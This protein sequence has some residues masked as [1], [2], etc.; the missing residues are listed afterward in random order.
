MKKHGILIICIIAILMTSSYAF[1]IPLGKNITVYDGMKG[2]WAWYGS[3]EDDEVEPGNIYTQYWDLEGF[4]LN[5]STLTMVGG[6]DFAEGYMDQASGDIFIDIDNDS[7]FGPANTDSGRDDQI[8]ENTFGYDYVIDLDFASA[9]YSVYELVDGS[10]TVLINNSGAS[11][12]PASNPWKYNDGGVLLEQNQSMGY[13]SDLD[14]DEV[15]GLAGDTHYAASVDLSFLQGSDFVSHF[16]MACGNDNLRGSSVPEPSS[17]I[18][19]GIG[20]GMIGI[21]SWMRRKSKNQK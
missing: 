14:S 3:Q 5:G 11:A 6:F 2:D 19:L 9:S 20:I 15:D 10:S 1:A 12:N 18:L 8:V 17:M 13:W 21:T 4:F 16:T 7:V